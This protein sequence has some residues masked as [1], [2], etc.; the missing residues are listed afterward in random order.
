MAQKPEYFVWHG[1]MNRCYMPTHMSFS[2]YGGRG[3]K[4]CKRWHKFEN[5][6]ADMGDRPAPKLMLERI[7]NESGYSPTNCKWATRKEQAANKRS[8]GWNKLTA[9]DA[10]AIRADPRR[11]WRIAEDYNVT[12]SMIGHIKR[13]ECFAD[14]GGPLV[15]NPRGNAKLTTAQFNAIRADARRHWEI[16]VDYGVNRSRISTIKRT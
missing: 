12:R 15:A 13:E 6:L 7:D 9:T 10:R 4:V 16:A 2:N 14:V 8:H 1:M 5:F 11:Y 3:I